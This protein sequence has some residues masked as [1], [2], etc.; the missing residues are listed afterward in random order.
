MRAGARVRRRS[1]EAMRTS[2]LLLVATIFS[3]GCSVVQRPTAVFRDASL[4]EVDQNGLTL[5][6]DLSLQNPN[7]VAL[8][9][10]KA[11][12]GLSLAGTKVLEGTAK[13]EGSIPANG[14]FPVRLPV[15]LTYENLLSAEQAIVK[16]GG[17]IPY[18]FTGGLDVGEGA[19][20]PFLTK[21]ARVPLEYQGTLDVKE[22]VAKGRDV[23]NSPAGR[24]LAM[25]L[26]GGWLGR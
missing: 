24:K 11:D 18:S 3:V 6:F 13:P 7:S 1:T 2:L 5:N 4:G 26:V 25:D 16:G 17:K 9:L 23:M 8:P 10:S 20:L 15:K 19:G 14:E 12:Y 21:G 22:V